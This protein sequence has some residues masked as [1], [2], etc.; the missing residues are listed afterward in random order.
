MSG[1]CQVLWHYAEEE[2]QTLEKNTFA[3]FKVMSAPTSH[4]GKVDILPPYHKT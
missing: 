1:F 3:A 2:I 4:K